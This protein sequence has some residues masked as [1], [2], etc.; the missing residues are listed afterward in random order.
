MFD[1]SKHGF[2]V[3]SPYGTRQDPFNG[4]PTFHTG[5]D[6]VKA[7]KAPIFAFMGGEVVHA[8]EG[9]TGT[10]FG[11]FGIVVA[12]KDERGALHCYAHL[13]SCSVKVGQKVAAGQEVG[14][15][16]TTGRST[17]SHLH[18][19]VR[20]KSAPS[21]G[22]DCH[23]NPG[24]YLAK[25]LNQEKGTGNVKQKDFISKIAAAAVEDMKR[26]GI[27]ASLTIAQAALESNWGESGL[28]TKAKNLFGIKG[29]GP[30]GSVRMLTKEYRPDGTSYQ[31][32]AD[33]RKYNNWGESIADHSQLILNGTKDKP[34][35]YHGV[36]HADYKTACYEIWR[37]TYATDP[38]Y[39][40]LLIDLIE[41]HGL[42]KYDTMGKVEQASIEVNGKKIAEGPLINGYVFAPV[43]TV[44][45]ALGCRVGWDGKSATIGGKPVPGCQMINGNA[46]APVRAVA[47]AA[48]AKVQW[49]GKERKVTI[50]K[51]I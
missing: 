8:R 46:Y 34:K 35:R 39:P 5:I 37:G 41:Q 6:L 15:Q 27:P 9:Q 20:T 38:G 2:R 43:R 36:L 23:T 40:Q 32:E 13:N 45:V 44:G 4:K 17:G 24:E 25:H 3:T 7:H 49:N 22:F 50:S 48:D 28:T 19:E 11:N 12:L 30:A 51:K 14:K 42:Q 26:T 31:I 18:Y 47:E 1:W 29:R 10:G 21:F 16:G 33:F